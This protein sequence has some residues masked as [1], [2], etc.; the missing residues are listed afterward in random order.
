MRFFNTI[1]NALCKSGDIA[2][3]IKFMRIMEDRGLKP[4]L[5][6]YSVIISGYIKC[7]EMENAMRMFSEAK[8]NR[9]KL[10]PVMYHT[11]IRGYCRLERFE[12]AVKLL[13][14][15]GVRANTDEYD[16]LKLLIGVYGGE[17]N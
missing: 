5:F 11:I 17:V 6:T 13:E 15:Y 12:K 16:K 7:G 8:K 3:A 1:I 4:D 14:E 9:E 2:E 10:T